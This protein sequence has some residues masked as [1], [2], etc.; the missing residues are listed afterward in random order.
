VL[1]HGLRTLIEHPAIGAVRVIIHPDDRAHYDTA[2]AG[3]DLL[4]PVAGGVQRQDSVRN[5]LESLIAAAPDLVLIHDGARP[6][7]DGPIIDRV[8]AGWRA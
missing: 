5:G 4:E 7:L 1:R 8:L 6:L 2:T 3:L